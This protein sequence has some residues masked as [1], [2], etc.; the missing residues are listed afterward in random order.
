MSLDSGFIVVMSKV[1]EL[2]QAQLS[3]EAVLLGADVTARATSYWDPSPTQALAIVRPETTEQVSAVLKICHDQDQAV[4]LAGGLTGVVEGA[5][6]GPD[7]IVISLE[8]MNQIEVVDELDNTA[9]V[10]AGAILQK[11]QEELDD[12]GFLFP[13]DLGARGSCTIGGNIATNAGG[14]NVLRYGMMRNLV[15]GLEAVL[16]DGT[17]VSSMNQMLKNNTGYDLKQLFIGSEGTLGVV[18]RAVLRLYPLPSS[19]QTVLFA[20]NSFAA[21]TTVLQRMNAELAGTLSAYEVMWNN[22]YKDV[23]AEGF[24]RP[25]LER[26]HPFYVL[27]EAEGVDSESDIERFERMLASAMEQGTIVDAVIARS[28]ADRQALWIVREEFEP[29]L[30]AYLYD[31]SL[32]KRHMEVYVEKLTQQLADWRDDSVGYIFGHIA[33]G[34]LHIFVTPYDEG[35]HHDTVDKIVY[36]CLAGLSG[37]VSAEHGIGKEKLQWLSSSRSQSEIDL[38]RQLKNMIDPKNILNSGKVIS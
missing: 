22:Y 2:I 24:H 33:D 4:V 13:L 18:T 10:Q 6:A 11:V 38:M 31:I 14:V 1:I 5:V 21:V 17:I 23:T 9:V 26:N 28:E 35:S 25:P 34:N 20:A 19:R 12:K 16:A 30:P 8:R 15:L 27:A 29:L 3:N 36:G 37:S 32:P 7:D